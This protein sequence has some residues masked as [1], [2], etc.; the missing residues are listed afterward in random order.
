MGLGL[1]LNCL[2][3]MKTGQRRDMANFAIT[4]CPTVIP[5]PTPQ[6]TAIGSLA[7]PTCWDHIGGGEQPAEQKR[8]LL[9][10]T[11]ALR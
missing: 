9:I 4:L 10:A 5:I 7:V 6:G 8:P 2:S 1:C 11:G 3:E